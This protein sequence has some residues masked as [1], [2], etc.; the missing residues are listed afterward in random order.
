MEEQEQRR[1]R[2]TRCV[3]SP[4]GGDFA[5]I[6]VE[7][8]R[9]SVIEGVDDDRVLLQSTFNIRGLSVDQIKDVAIKHAKTLMNRCVTDPHARFE[10]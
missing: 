3:I 7:L 5:K 2:M 9:D 4:N 1:E 10:E 8:V 6:E